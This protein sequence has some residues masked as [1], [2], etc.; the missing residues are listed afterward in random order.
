M[1]G[2][3]IM[4]VICLFYTYAKRRIIVLPPPD[5]IAKNFIVE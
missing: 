1:D 5:A 4:T 2:G 3:A